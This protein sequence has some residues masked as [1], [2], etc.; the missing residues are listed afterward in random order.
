MQEEPFGVIIR[1][2]EFSDGMPQ[3]A[4]Y[5]LALERLD[6]S[7]LTLARTPSKFLVSMRHLHNR[8]ASWHTYAPGRSWW[9]LWLPRPCAYQGRPHV[10]RQSPAKGVGVA[11]CQIMAGVRHP[12]LAGLAACLQR[13][14][15]KGSHC[16]NRRQRTSTWQK[17]LCSPSPHPR[18][19]RHVTLAPLLHSLL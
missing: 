5:N 6:A 19:R 12:F 14:E 1:L 3:S 2:R 16:P 9:S 8:L 4:K 17:K 7:S 18:Y 13:L 11:I 10:L 15:E